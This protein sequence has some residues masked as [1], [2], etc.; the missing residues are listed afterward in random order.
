MGLVIGNSGNQNHLMKIAA[1]TKKTAD[2]VVQL[3]QAVIQRGQTT[4]IDP[5]TALYPAP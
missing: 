3:A 4:G 2:A 1:N 5:K